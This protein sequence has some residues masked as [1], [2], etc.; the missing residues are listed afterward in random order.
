MRNHVEKM[1]PPP[2]RGQRRRIARA[3]IVPR[4]TIRFDMAEV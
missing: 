4:G 1:F 3:N 2:Q